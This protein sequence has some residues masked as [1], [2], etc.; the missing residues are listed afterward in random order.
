MSRSKSTRAEIVSAAGELEQLLQQRGARG[1]GLMEKAQSLAAHLP[2]TLLADI[3]QVARERNSAIHDEAYTPPNAHSVLTS[4]ARAKA[5]LVDL[6][7]FSARASLHSLRRLVP[8]LQ[9]EAL[10][11]W[12]ALFALLFYGA[13][14]PTTWLLEFVN[15]LELEWRAP[16]S[17]GLVLRW[18]TAL[19]LGYLAFIVARNL[20]IA[21]EDGLDGRTKL[22]QAAAVAVTVLLVPFPAFSTAEALAL[23]RDVAPFA[24]VGTLVWAAPTWWLARKRAAA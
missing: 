2:A 18:I 11:V 23:Y 17:L 1:K 22:H 20:L 21:V 16:S 10:L 9:G 15:G 8:V 24:I 6:P 7:A 14:Y 4:A 5:A 3:Q 13:Q 12:F 19:L